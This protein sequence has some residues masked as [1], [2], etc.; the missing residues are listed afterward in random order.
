MPQ[1]KA[2]ENG[3]SR[4]PCLRWCSCR[5]DRWCGSG[6]WCWRPRC[7]CCC[8][9]PILTAMVT[10][11]IQISSHPTPLPFQNM[12][13]HVHKLTPTLL[14]EITAR[15]VCGILP[16]QHIM[17]SQRCESFSFYLF[18]DLR[19]CSFPEQSSSGRP[20]TGLLW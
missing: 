7:S 12:I 8:C 16:V 13:A 15:F 1:G 9:L 14:A 19:L 10:S 17:S 3:T 5:L 2:S 6:C 18:N 20:R 4:L 11:L